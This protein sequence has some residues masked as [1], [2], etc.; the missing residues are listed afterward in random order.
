MQAS[1]MHDD[2]KA[3]FHSQAKKYIKAYVYQV[4]QIHNKF[5]YTYETEGHLTMTSR[6]WIN[7]E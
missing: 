6:S 3:S 4:S 2:G 5:F 1:F 7:I